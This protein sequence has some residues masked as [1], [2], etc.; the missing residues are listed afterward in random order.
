M[1]THILAVVPKRWYGVRRALSCYTSHI[2]TPDEAK[3]AIDALRPQTVVFGCYQPEWYP[4]VAHALFHRARCV[5]SW[6]A[7]TILNDFDEQNREWLYTAISA[8]RRGFLHE[9]VIP[10]RGLA[11]VWSDAGLPASYLPLTFTP[12]TVDMQPPA[13]GIHLGLFGTGH[14]WKNM[15]TQALAAHVLHRRH[16]NVTLHVQNDFAIRDVR[17]YFDIPVLQHREITDDADYHRVVGSMHVNLI[18]SLSET[19]SYLG[20]ESLAL[21]VPILTT[22]VTPILDTSWGALRDH[23]ILHKFDDPV[24]IANRIELI[25]RQRDRLRDE[26]R[27]HILSFN[28]SQRSSVEKVRAAWMRPL[29]S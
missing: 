10:H 9:L 22:A 25:L 14:P 12:P 6:F 20:A 28:E 16:G 7:S 29:S 13:D 23:C 17:R 3:R 2:V 26:G 1:E 5:A 24:E 11:S 18:M 4:I 27:T 19:Y 21:G 8:V 15:E